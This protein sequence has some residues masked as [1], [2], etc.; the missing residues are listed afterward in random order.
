MVGSFS[1]E[2]VPGT[3][4]TSR[5]EASYAA[6][7]ACLHRHRWTLH[8]FSRGSRYAMMFVDSASRLKRPYGTRE[9]SAAAICSVAKRFVAD[10]G[11]PRAFHTDSGTDYSNNMFVDFCNA[12]ESRREFTAPYTPQQNGPVESAISRAFKTG[13]APRLGVPH[14][15]PNIRL[16]D[17][18]L[19]C[20]DA[21]ETSLWL[22]SLLWASECYNRAATSVNDERLPPYESFYGSRPRLP[23]LPFL[24]P[25]Y[26]R[27]PR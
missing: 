26:P 24:Q 13:H 10:K 25:A 8:N 14:L 9:K 27:V 17:I 22:E 5:D 3:Y 20:T 23:V 7:G 2:R 6:A 16:E 4:S 11:V 18:L 12:L 1:G 15:Y 19:G 21:A